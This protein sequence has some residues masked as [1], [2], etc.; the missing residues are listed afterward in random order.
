MVRFRETFH[1]TDVVAPLDA[2][3]SAL[4]TVAYRS[5][6]V[7]SKIRP[8]GMSFDSTVEFFPSGMPRSDGVITENEHSLLEQKR[9]NYLWIDVD[10]VDE[11][12][13]VIVGDGHP[14]PLLRRLQMPEQNML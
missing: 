14:S 10:G 7:P 3:F 9:N 12:S 13:I 4:G 6:A 2:S 11:N 1:C 8:R 5:V